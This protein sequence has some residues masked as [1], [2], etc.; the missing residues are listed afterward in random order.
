VVLVDH[1]RVAQDRPAGVRGLGAFLEPVQRLGAV[2]LDESGVLVGVVSTDPLD[3]L[4]VA[5]GALISHYQMVVGLA[6]LAFS[7]KADAGR[8]VAL[9]G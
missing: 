1:A 9:V 7:L 8:H 5:R 2:K 3:V 4:T 6:F